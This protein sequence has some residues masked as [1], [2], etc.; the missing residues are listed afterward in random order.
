MKRLSTFLLV[1]ALLFTNIPLAYASD[2]DDMIRV[3]SVEIDGELYTYETISERDG[4][5]RVNISDEKGKTQVLLFSAND[6]TFT[7]DGDVIAVVTENDFSAGGGANVNSSSDWVYQG[8]YSKSISWAKGV[9]V[10][11]VAGVIAVAVTNLGAAGVIAAMGSTALGVL[12]ACAIG[13]TVYGY[14]YLCTVG[15]TVTTRINW[16][17]YA[18]TGERYPAS[19]TYIKFY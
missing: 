14:V 19:G 6:N 3:E 8:M 10:A 11:V 1:F 12:A 9:T 17:F 16:C 5:I 15:S 13:G 7:L 18:S 2:G 4:N